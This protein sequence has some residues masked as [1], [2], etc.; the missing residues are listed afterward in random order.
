MRRPKIKPIIILNEYGTTERDWIN[1]DHIDDIWN[2]MKNDGIILPPYK[3]IHRKNLNKLDLRILTGDN[4]YRIVFK[5]WNYETNEYDVYDIHFKKGFI[6][7]LATV[8]HLFRGIVGNDDY[9]VRV[10]AMIHDSLYLTHK[11]S[12]KVA[13]YI[14]ACAMVHYDKS[15]KRKLYSFGVNTRKAKK[16]YKSINPTTHWAK[17]FVEIKVNGK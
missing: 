1:P 14:F 4:G 15:R 16:G 12:W 3:S 11:V 8:P 5:V 9:I 2:R 17:D 6:W 13:N 7:D 10:P